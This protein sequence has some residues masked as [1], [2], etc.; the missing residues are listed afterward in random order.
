MVP[1]NGTKVVKNGTSTPLPSSCN[2][3]KVSVN[4]ISFCPHGGRNISRNYFL[5]RKAEYIVHLFNSFLIPSKNIYIES[6]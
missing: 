1:E 4:L 5:F 6:S 2:D 3:K